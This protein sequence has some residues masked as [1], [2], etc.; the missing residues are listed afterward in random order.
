MHTCTHIE[1]TN[2]YTTDTATHPPPPAAEPPQ[3]GPDEGGAQ[4]DERQ[5]L[6]Q[7]LQ[8]FLLIGVVCWVVLGC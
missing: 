1:T 5:A 6:G 4:G 7:A 2:A 3:H 8:E